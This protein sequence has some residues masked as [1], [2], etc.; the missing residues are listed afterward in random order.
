MHGFL[1][2]VATA[3][4]APYAALAA[5]FLVLGHAIAQRD[6]WSLVDTLLQHA[7]WIMPWGLV[8]FALALVAIAVLG[9]VPH[10]RWIGAA[11]L[12][13]LAAASLV[14]L[15]TLESGPLDAGGIVFLLPAVAVLAYAAWLAIAET[16]ARN[17]GA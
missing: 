8:G 17:A 15:V 7:L 10:S 4:L 14:V 6:L 2:V 16:R 1:H 9:A 5:A 3:V 11:I 13:A 12:G